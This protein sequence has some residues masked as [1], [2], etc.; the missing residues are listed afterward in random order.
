MALKENYIKLFNYIRSNKK[1]IYL[2]S[3]IFA[4]SFITGIIEPNF[5]IDYQ[6]KIIAEL[7]ALS[8]E[9]FFGF[10]ASI[11]S[12]N[13]QASILGILFGAILVPT[14]ALLI[15][16]GYIFGA[17]TSRALTEVGL[18]KVLLSILPH[19]I[20]EIP[21]A[22]LS[23]TLGMAIGITAFR[24][25]RDSKKGE[26][27]KVIGVI[28]RNYKKAVLAFLLVI[29]PLLLV[30]GIIEGALFTY[31][32]L[33]VSLKMQ[34]VL[35]SLVLIYLFYFS[36]KLLKAYKKN[37]DPRVIT[38]L[39]LIFFVSVFLW[40]EAYGI[41]VKDLFDKFVF[42]RAL[43]VI[44]PL[45][46][47][48]FY[49]YLENLRYKEEKQKMQIKGAFQQYVSPAIIDEIMK[50]P[51]KLKLG[52][53]KKE[54]TIFFS[55]IRDF[56]TISEKLGPEQLVHV[57]NQY[58]SKMT[59][60]ILK[61][62]GVV[63]KYIGDAIMAF[64]NAP[65]DV[66]NHEEI[67][68]QSSLEMIESLGILKKQW[69]DEKIPEINIGIGMN[70]GEAVVGNMGSAQRFDYTIMGDNVNIASRL[71]GLNKIYGT[72]I[73]ISEFTYE[74]VKHKFACRELDFVRVKGKTK[75]LK[76]Y[77]LIGS[78]EEIKKQYLDFINIFE[79]ALSLYK[80]GEWS[81]A[82][83]TFEK[84]LKIKEDKPS[85]IFIERCAEFKK[86]PP[87]HWDGVYEVKTK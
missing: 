57:L 21:A 15:V 7:M 28:A 67:A 44:I 62:K 42:L 66:Q 29:L 78:K 82:V 54:M 3:V 1:I 87:K 2:C 84:A 56:S 39:I 71:E 81:E 83:K 68:C 85:R 13:I 55:D 65:L 20:F 25:L 46:T 10:T 77:E 76:I 63:D 34:K 69:H 26:R 24:Y 17:V 79:N 37:R 4:V 52:G 36:A 47:L 38:L 58:L 22:I 18:E 23:Y 72:A 64:W 30:A 8:G 35:F 11:I 16:N 9:R 12:A 43:L 74:K 45:V 48:L 50:H 33:L 59:D 75:P 73:I 49:L 51:E 70:T 27:K 86:H 14:V 31:Y 61:N 60:I 80:N 53:E 40:M 5:F 19:S 32:P 6:K 41:K